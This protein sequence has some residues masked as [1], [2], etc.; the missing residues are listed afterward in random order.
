MTQAAAAA[1]E[2]ADED[3]GQVGINAAVLKAVLT[4]LE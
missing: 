2:F 3:C 1:T 4:N